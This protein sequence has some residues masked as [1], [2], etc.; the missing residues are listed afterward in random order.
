MRLT[1]T[2]GGYESCDRLLSMPSLAIGTWQ[3]GAD[4]A[5][6]G[7]TPSPDDPCGV[8]N[9]SAYRAF[10]L[11]KAGIELSE[12]RYLEVARRESELRC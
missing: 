11:T 6:C 10:L 1:R 12:P 5:S 2:R 4:A 9:A 7:Y 8:I 3:T